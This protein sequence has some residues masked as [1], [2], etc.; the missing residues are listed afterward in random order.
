VNPRFRIG[1]EA[2]V[3]FYQL[4]ATAR[5]ADGTVTARHPWNGTRVY[6]RKDARWV[7]VHSHRSFV[8][9]VRPGGGV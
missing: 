1:S 6:A 4:E 5:R 9:S 3:L 2:V 7:L 8:G